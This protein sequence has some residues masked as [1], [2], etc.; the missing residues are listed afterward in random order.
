MQYPVPSLAYLTLPEPTE[1]VLNLQV[2][3]ALLRCHLT[4]DQLYQLNAQ[5][6]D[7]LVRGKIRPE[8]QPELPFD[9]ARH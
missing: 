8:N 7:A 9:Q 3:G 4:R 6:A 1:P 2:N 5:F